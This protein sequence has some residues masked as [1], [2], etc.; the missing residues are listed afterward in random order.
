[1]C[2]VHTWVRGCGPHTPSY[3]QA[4]GDSSIALPYAERTEEPV[5]IR[6]LT[7]HGWAAGGRLPAPSTRQA[8]RPRI[9]EPPRLGTARS[10]CDSQSCH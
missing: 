3:S 8:I 6:L 9:R 10:S 1:V 4:R 2:P 5:G 7:V